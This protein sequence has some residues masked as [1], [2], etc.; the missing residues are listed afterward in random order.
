MI[1]KDFFFFFLGMIITEEI[2]FILSRGCEEFHIVEV[3]ELPAS[4]ECTFETGSLTHSGSCCLS[5][6]EH[7]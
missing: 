5:Q 7:R 2:D 1:L 3:F 6:R 4:K